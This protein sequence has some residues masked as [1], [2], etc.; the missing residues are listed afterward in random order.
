MPGT[1]LDHKNVQ[2]GKAWGQIKGKQEQ[3]LD[4]INLEVVQNGDYKDVEDLDEK[5]ETYKGKFIEYD[6]DGSGDLD[7]TDVSYMMEK[8]GQPKNVL[9]KKKII[10]EID[11]DGSGTVSYR[12]FL[13]M[14]LG[15]KSSIMKIILMFEEKNKEKERPSGPPPKRDLSSLP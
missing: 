11:L 9:E 15:N 10:A 5:L 6:L 8:L 3:A 14:M 1:K 7:V 13:K 4:D 2:G 12:E